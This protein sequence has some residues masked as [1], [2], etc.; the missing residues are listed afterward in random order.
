MSVLIASTAYAERVEVGQREFQIPDGYE[1]ELAIRPGLTERPIVVDFDANG[2]LYVAESSGTNDDVHQQLKEKPH[3]ILRLSDTDGDGIF[4]KRT[5]F[6]DQLMFPEGVLCHGGSV[7]VAAPPQILKLTDHNNDGLADQREVWFDGK[8]LTG[9]ANDLHGP[10]QGLDGFIYWCKGAFAEQTYETADGQPFVTRAAHIFRRAPNGGVATPVMTGGMDNPVEVVFTETGERIFNTTFFQHPANGQRDGLVH[11]IYGGVY[12]KD[13]GVLD[14]HPRTGPLMPVMTHLG[15]A[16]PSG[17]ARLES[18]SLGFEG[19]LLTAC[20]NLHSVTR[21]ELVPHGAS[22]QTKDDVLVSSDDLDF[23]P[24]DVIEDA[25]GSVLIVDTGGWYK[26]CCP[27]SQLHKPDVTGAIYRL[28]KR[29]TER[30][31]DP[32]G[33]QIPWKTL[34]A[35]QLS[36]LLADDRF[37]VRRRAITE[38]GSRQDAVVSQLQKT[39]KSSPDRRAALNAIWAACRISSPSAREVARLGLFHQSPSVRQASSHGASLFPSDKSSSGRLVELLDDDSLHVQRAAAEAIG[40]LGVTMAIPRILNRL[41]DDIDRTLQHSLTYALIEMGPRSIPQ[42]LA[43]LSS[44]KVTQKCATLTALI[45]MENGRLAVSQDQLL[46][47]LN[48]KYSEIRRLAT[49]IA[50]ARPEWSDSFVALYRREIDEDVGRL[51][52]F[53]ADLGALAGQTAINQFIAELL[54]RQDVSEN[55]KASLIECVPF[56]VGEIEETLPTLLRD[57]SPDVVELVVRKLMERPELNKSLRDEMERVATDKDA[58]P[59]TRLLAAR[60]LKTL[61]PKLFAQVTHYMSDE[62]PAATRSLALGVLENVELQPT[63]LVELAKAVPAV[64]ALELSRLLRVFEKSKSPDVGK[65]LFESLMESNAATALRADQLASLA[66]QFG[67]DAQVLAARLLK[68]SAGSLAMQ[69][70]RLDDLM[71]D[72]PDGDIRR[73]Q[74]IFH[75]Q[76]QACFTCH[77]VGYR[78]GTVGPDLSRIGRTRS[79]RDLLE[80]IIYPSASFVRSYEPVNVVT[81][82]GRQWTGTIRDQSSTEL[83]LQLNATEIKMIRSDDIETMLPGKVSIMPSGLEKQLTNDELADLLAFL[84]SRK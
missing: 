54:L 34:S 48:S 39:V 50:K 13:H 3:S 21:H 12:G 79:R 74:E 68:D 9:C 45:G 69:T 42:L 2:H 23:H 56:N 1:L 31:A 58:T 29:D 38:I 76:K 19:H 33:L 26:L 20:F 5:V 32:R 49:S 72:L 25:D 6:A 37:A 78:G 47:L 8:T 55:A 57:R 61:G 17:L 81:A 7:Y 46:Q 15:A 84:E 80:A 60:Q 71:A 43:A 83:K 64:G 82:D 22:F 18:D 53:S 14:G 44:N 10:Y 35:T 16:A 63:Q 66:E 75:N 4:D 36:K 65:V 59:A 67:D 62:H 70:Q 27:T 51:A 52:A 40:R 41:D 30:R 28:K 77:A 11:A 24:T 73:G